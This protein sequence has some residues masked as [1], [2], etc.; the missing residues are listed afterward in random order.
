MKLSAADYDALFTE[1]NTM[2]QRVKSLL[3]RQA[4]AVP[5][6]TDPA[7]TDA[8]IA[9]ARTADTLSRIYATLLAF[10]APPEVLR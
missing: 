5:A 8:L 10:Y 6:D 2:R 7:Y 3:A 9:V 1:L 4:A